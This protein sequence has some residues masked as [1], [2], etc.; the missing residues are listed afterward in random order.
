MEI[1][2]RKCWCFAASCLTF[3]KT[4]SSIINICLEIRGA[5][6]R[7]RNVH[8]RETW[9]HTYIFYHWT[10]HALNRL[11]SDADTERSVRDWHFLAH[12]FL[13]WRLFHTLNFTLAWFY[14]RYVYL[15]ST[16]TKPLA[17]LSLLS[18]SSSHMFDRCNDGGRCYSAFSKHANGLVIAKLLNEF[19]IP[20]RNCDS[21]QKHE[22][23]SERYA[24][25]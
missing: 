5:S 18:P 11:Q 20:Q 8:G 23:E 12:R 15:Q 7:F 25:K 2:E 21:E 13:P 19:S 6:L 17:S 24:T 3:Y 9:D 22:R 10:L 14:F 4:S 1:W 16:S